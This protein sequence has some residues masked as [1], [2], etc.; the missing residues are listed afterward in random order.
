MPIPVY[1]RQF[2]KAVIERAQRN[3]GA[4]RTVKRN[5]KRYKRRAVASGKLKESLTYTVK[6]TEKG[7]I[8][9]FGAKGP[10]KKY[11]M[12]VEYGRGPSRNGPSKGSGKLKQQIKNWIKEKNIRPRRNGR[13]VKSMPEA[14]EGLAYVISRNIHKNGIPPLE[15]YKEAIND[16]VEEMAQSISQKRVDELMK[17]RFGK[18]V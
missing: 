16:T 6:E 13:I 4:E 17:K 12:F 1:I 10:A 11:A 18:K 2:G 14:I 5:G 3:L 7:F 9:N 15:Y 8:I